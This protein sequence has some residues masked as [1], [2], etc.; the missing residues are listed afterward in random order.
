MSQNSKPYVLK[1]RNRIVSESDTATVSAATANVM[2]PYVPRFV[3][4][5][6]PS[7]IEQPVT[8]P[9]TSPTTDRPINAVAGYQAID[10]NKALPVV[11][12]APYVPRFKASNQNTDTCFSSN[13]KTPA[14]GPVVGPVVGVIL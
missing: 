14:V 8:T 7:R 3:V 2:K 12:A 13:T 6:E 4:Q 9:T 5:T 1:S 10:A 11:A